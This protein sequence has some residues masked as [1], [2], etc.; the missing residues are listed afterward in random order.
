[1]KSDLTENIYSRFTAITVFLYAILQFN[2]FFSQN[3]SYS[4]LIPWDVSKKII[5]NEVEIIVPV[6]K[7]QDYKGTSPHFFWQEKLPLGGE[8]EVQVSDIVYGPSESTDLGLL[9]HNGIDIPQQPRYEAKA[10]KARTQRYMS[11]SLFPFVMQDGVLKRIMGFTVRALPAQLVTLTPQKSFVASSVLSD[12]DSK[13]YKIGVRADGIYKIDRSFLSS[14][15]I[16]IASVDPQSIHIYGNG[17]GKLD[18]LNS[19]YRVDDLAKNAIQIIGEQDG[20]FNEGDY[21]LFHAWGP[22]KWL[23]NGQIFRRDLNIYS[24]V[25][26]YYIRICA[27][28]APLR[29][30]NAPVASG[31]FTQSV[32]DYN[33]FDIVESED[34]SLVGGGQRWYGDVFDVEL[35]RNYTFSIPAL[36]TAVPVRFQ[37]SL[38]HNARIPGSSVNL[39]VNGT[40]IESSSLDSGTLDFRRKEFN[41][42]YT[43][44]SGTLAFRMTVTRNSPT[45]L[46]YL[47]K[48]ELNARRNLVFMGDY[49]RFRDLPSIAVG[50]VTRFTV[51]GIQ[52]ANYFVWDVTNRQVPR[53]ITGTLSGTDF[54]FDANTDTLR[55]FA[56]SNGSVYLTPEISGNVVAQ[57]LHALPFADMLVVTHPDFVSYAE[58]LANIHRNEGMQV[59]VVTTEQI[60]NEFSSGSQ[61]PTAIKWFAKMFYDRANGNPS[62]MPK[63]LLLFGDGTYDPKNRVS[64]NNYFMPTYQ[65]ISSENHIDALVTDD[66]FGMLDNNESLADG[67]L[68]DINVGRLLISNGQQANDQI[69]KIEKYMSKGGET[70]GSAADCC[71]GTNASAGVFGDWRLNYV[72]ITDDEQDGDFVTKDAEPQF[73]QVTA[74]H[75]EMNSD[76]IY[77]DAYSQIS[78]AGGER[79]PDV[80]DAITNRIQRGALIMNYIGHGGETG[81]AD[82]RIVTIPQIL[83][84]TNADKLCLFVSAT[85]EFTKFDDPSRISAGE[86]VSMSPA[87]GGIA[88][89]TTTR[90]V[91]V[92]VNTQIGKKFYENVFD[93]DANMQPLTFGE[94]MTRTKNQTTTSGVN[95][96]CFMLVGDPALKIALPSLKIVTDSINGISPDLAND[97]I[98]ALSKMRIKGHVV[99]QNGNVMTDF[100]G[101]LSPTIYDKPKAQHTLGQNIKS[102]VIDFTTQ[103]NA[104]YKGKV[105]VTNG[106]FDFSFVVPKDI[107]F[108]YG[109]GKISYY[110][111]TELIDAGGMDSRFI[112]G[113]LNAA[114]LNDN[115]APLVE[116]YL[117]DDSF[118]SGGI[119]NENPK[120]IAKVSDENGVNTVGNGI[121][122]DI[123]AILD[124]NTADPIVLNDYYSADL[125]M[126]QSG[127]VTYDF[128]KLAPGKHSLSFKI[129]DVNNNSAE[130]HLDFVVVEKQEIALDHV[131]NYPNP[132]TT[133]TEFFFEHNQ[134]CSALETQIQVYTVSGKL[135]RTINELVKTQ[136]F[137]T[138]GISWDGRDDFGDKIGRGVYVYRITVR[139]AEGETAQKLEKLVILN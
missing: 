79:Y 20:V 130:S 52:N 12:P 63:N 50:N 15:G 38:A 78:G 45:V 82:E 88:L 27:A 55:E 101:L 44:S 56:V 33:Y 31:A 71:S 65:V 5:S 40:T 136:G 113:G 120:L 10:T 133:K 13:W 99:D 26:Y 126:Y 110:G 30:A 80:N 106:Y 4:L 6:I 73:E 94:I 87:G 9:N 125:N 19:A 85:C 118:V 137:R 51:S 57:N 97:T 83:S 117:N 135:V 59:H 16:D 42:T 131:L 84:W 129:W 66:Y 134:V 21:I 75:P 107:N 127:K 128:S 58:R 47:D 103:K 48:I 49:F 100:N 64:N 112:L 46:T 86:W 90:A 122:H 81:A 91:Y 14:L 8:Y 70:V 3:D 67:D 72:Q 22:N 102:P 105:S 28:E 119:T 37:T 36:N 39:S 108:A 11:V 53:I 93:R 18:E 35:T 116:L 17:S 61:D 68:M 114:G 62:L 95:R 24:D 1:M 25:S 139:T 41:D 115:V 92:S 109:N 104:V 60:Y 123:V 124:G 54:I 138:E 121:G 34:K 74:E 32:T 89:M 2:T 96:R 77:S 29:I 7:N 43:A 23:R 76:K 98:E 111:N 69:A 132:F